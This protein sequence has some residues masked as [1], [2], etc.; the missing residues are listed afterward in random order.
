MENEVKQRKLAA[1]SLI[2]TRFVCVTASVLSS[3]LKNG[4][5]KP[6]APNKGMHLTSLRDL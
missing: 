4:Y 3:P 2:L 6:N 1:V 5:G